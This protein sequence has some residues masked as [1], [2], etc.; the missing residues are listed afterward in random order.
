MS[1]VFT[2]LAKGL[3]SLFHPRM[4]LLTVW[5][6]LIAMTIWGGAALFY[7]HDWAQGISHLVAE[8]P[9]QNF[10]AN[11]DMEWLAHFLVTFLIVLLLVPLAYTTALL[12]TAIFAMPAMVRHVAK[13][14]YPDLEMR[15]GGTFAG[16]VWNSLFAVVIFT[17]MWVAT[18]PLWLFPAFA[19]LIP[20]LLAAYLNQRL[21]T[22]DALADHADETEIQRI[23][24]DATG[25]LYLLGGLLAL[26]QF[27]PILHFFAPVYIGLSYIHFCLAQLTRL[28]GSVPP[29]SMPVTGDQAPA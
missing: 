1:D 25:K 2:A 7:W 13:R 17:V 5:P 14:D 12:I 15:R 18:L 21:F 11:H 9:A 10:L 19:W 23:R 27:I 29:A 26:I 3:R 20:L 16:S 22:Y 28:R 24:E 6:M 4:L 8:T